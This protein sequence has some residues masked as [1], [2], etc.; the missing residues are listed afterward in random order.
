MGIAKISS[1]RRN[2]ALSC[3]EQPLPSGRYDYERRAQVCGIKGEN[4]EAGL[5]DNTQS[6][7]HGGGRLRRHYDPSTGGNG[8]GGG[9]AQ[10]GASSGKI[11][12]PEL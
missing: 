5:K 6:W 7:R 3:P 8:A 9:H 12:R 1:R 10:I 11:I 4:R 2:T